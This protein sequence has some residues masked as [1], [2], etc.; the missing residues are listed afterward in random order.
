MSDMT[1]HMKNELD[2][3]ITGNYG[4]GAFGDYDED[5]LSVCC[6]A[7]PHESTPD[8]SSDDPAGVCGA[9]LEFTG[10]ETEEESGAA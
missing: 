7:A 4:E 1:P 10:F 5:L 3:H 8:V 6:G 9:C 2:R